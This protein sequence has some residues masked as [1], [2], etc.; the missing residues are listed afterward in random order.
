MTEKE[1]LDLGFV[2]ENSSDTS[3]GVAEF[4]YYIKDI[5]NGLS[6]ISGCSDDI[7]DDD[8]YIEF[9]NTEIPIRYY[10]YSTVKELFILIEKGINKPKRR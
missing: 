9:F 1:L 2:K 4:Y 7:D 6:F 3:D 10:E 8:W 5:T